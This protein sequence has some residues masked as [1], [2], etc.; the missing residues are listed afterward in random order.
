MPDSGPLTQTQALALLRRTSDQ[1]WL[2]SELSGPDG[3]AVINA[4]TAIAAAASQAL[5]DQADRCTISDAPGG[6]PGVCTLTVSRRLGT[7]SIYIPQGY[8]FPTDEGI[9]LALAQPI[10]IPPGPDP[11]TFDLPLRTLRQTELV[12]TYDPAFDSLLDVGDLMATAGDAPLIYDSASNPVLGPGAADDD[13]ALRYSSST[14]IILAASDWLSAHGDERGQRRQPNEDTEEYRARIRLFPDAVSPNALAA[15]VHS[16]ASNAGLSDV[17]M[18]ETVDPQV[19]P[20]ALVANTMAVADSVFADADFFDDPIGE[21]R[22]EKLPWR[23][24]EQLSIREGRAYFR[25]AMHGQLKE[26]DGSILYFDDGFFDDEVWG[27]PDIGLHPSLLGALMTVPNAANRI[28]AGGVLEDFYVEDYAVEPPEGVALG[29]SSSASVTSVW[30]LYADPL[31]V[32]GSETRAWLY[33]DGLVSH[34]PGLA[35]ITQHFVVFFYADGSVSVTLPYYGLDA[36]HLTPS[37]LLSLPTP[38]PFLPTKPIVMILGLVQSDDAT[39]VNLA[40]TFWVTP[41]TL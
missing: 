37:Y 7:G 22:P 18:L 13:H 16:A 39:P 15:A 26:P 23:A 2:S 34:V 33:R 31:A 19:S 14:A 9:V 41:Y 3:T 29:S 17:Y 40:G 32:P 24:L 10:T 8:T 36:E 38:Y 27:Y 20:A 1:S 28:K 12:N 35:G 21:D 25:L 11:Q 6:T 4:R 30:A 5:Q